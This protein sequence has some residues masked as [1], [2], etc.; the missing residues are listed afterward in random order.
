MTSLAR[1]SFALL[2]LVLVLPLGAQTDLWQGDDLDLRAG[3]NNGIR[4]LFLRLEARKGQIPALSLRSRIIDDANIDKEIFGDM[5]PRGR[6]VY[7]GSEVTKSRG[8]DW[9]EHR[10]SLVGGRRIRVA[11]AIKGIEAATLRELVARGFDF[12]PERLPY[13][14]VSIIDGTK[15]LI[16]P[17][18]D[19]GPWKGRE[20]KAL[21]LDEVPMEKG[22]DRIESL[23]SI[24]RMLA[25][26]PSRERRLEALRQVSYYDTDE[27]ER[28][29]GVLLNLRVDGDEAVAK[30]VK[31]F[32]IQR[33]IYSQQELME[34]LF[35]FRGDDQDRWRR[36]LDLLD[37]IPEKAAARDGA[38]A[39]KHF[40]HDKKP[41]PEFA[42]RA[43]AKLEAYRKLIPAGLE[44]A[45]LPK[46]GPE[47]GWIPVVDP[48][49]LKRPD[50]PAPSSRPADPPTSRPG[51]EAGR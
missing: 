51:Q 40:L 11:T 48:I 34:A 42:R 3:L 37:K 28:H 16:Y 14:L 25:R 8:N 38:S 17:L 46:I 4:K 45:P 44:D 6:Y 9:V 1:S 18:I 47:T 49:P 2:V 41:A 21:I 43:E 30:A 39:L 23:Q 32:C 29:F 7:E 19:L 10:F 15:L 27:L 50:D 22:A 35:Q 12:G 36:S 5:V 13:A 20:E 33:N 24:L 31:A 26:G